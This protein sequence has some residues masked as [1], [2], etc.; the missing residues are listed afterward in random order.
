[1]PHEG[2]HEAS[3]HAFASGTTLRVSAIPAAGVS[4][5]G[6]SGAATGSAN[7]VSFVV[8]GQQRLVAHF[9]EDNGGSGGGSSGKNGVGG[10]SA[11]GGS[12]GGDP[13]SGAAEVT[14]S[15]NAGGTEAGS[16]IADGYFSGGDTFSTTNEIDTS[17][18]TDNA[19]PAAV[20]QTERYGEFGYTIPNRTPA[21]PQTVSLFFQESLWEQAGQRTFDVAIN[22]ATVLTAFDIYASAGGTNKAIAETFT[23]TADASGQVVIQFTKNGGPDNP[24]VC[25]ITVKGS[26]STGGGGGGDGGGDTG[27]G[28]GGNI[29]GPCD[30]YQAGNTPCVAAHSTV[31]A[32]YGAYSGRLYQVRRADNTTKDITALSAGGLAD[33]ASQD[34]F[35]AGTRCVI[36]IIYDQSPKHNDY[37]TAFLN[38]KPHMWAIKAGDSQ[39]GGLTTLYEGSR[40][41]GGYDP[42]RKQG[43]IILGTGG[44][45]S[46]GAIGDFFEGAM[47]SGYPTKEVDDA[48]QS[49]V[50]SAGYGR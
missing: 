13:G 2:P 9:S 49:N 29:T 33:S 27:G 26:A 31:R 15:I 17:L 11:G 40:P 4:F 34:E 6:W 50:V 21:S 22:G 7:P 39:S 37:V 25:G 5:R 35:C 36:S 30:I 12:G 48:V 24:K 32:L 41:N 19:P 28:S 46:Y 47:T 20:F 44:D 10:G 16:F 1:M 3:P 38:G 18:I 43:A 45:N 23:T 8:E 14:I 42:M